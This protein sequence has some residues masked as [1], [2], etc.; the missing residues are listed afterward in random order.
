MIGS[1]FDI[2]AQVSATNLIF[3]G[4]TIC[5]YSVDL[6]FDRTDLAVF[7]LVNVGGDCLLYQAV[8]L[9]LFQYHIST[10]NHN[11]SLLIQQRFSYTSPGDK[12]IR[13]INEKVTWSIDALRI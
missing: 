9:G 7:F 11:G 2:R 12:I 13:I 3:V 5:L 8:T 4:F 1:L 10:F 6:H